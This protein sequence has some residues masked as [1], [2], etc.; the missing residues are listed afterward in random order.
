MFTAPIKEDGLRE[1]AQCY[2]TKQL[3]SIVCYYEFYEE[4]TFKYFIINIEYFIKKYEFP[5]PE[6]KSYPKYD[7][8]K[9]WPKKYRYDECVQHYENKKLGYDSEKAEAIFDKKYF[10]DT[11]SDFKNYDAY[12]KLIEKELTKS[13]PD[14]VKISR[15]E[16]LKSTAYGRNERRSGR[17]VQKFEHTVDEKVTDNLLE[18]VKQKRRELN[19][20]RNN[21]RGI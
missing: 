2:A 18:R 6:N 10:N 1:S 8:A 5:W 14:L 16:G 11:V 21:G 15:L 4:I 12:Q 17:N 3:W 20:I 9:D 7:T 13:N 19:D